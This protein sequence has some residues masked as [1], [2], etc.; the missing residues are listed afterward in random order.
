MYNNGEQN[1]DLGQGYQGNPGNPVNQSNPGN[2]VNQSNTGNPGNPGNPGNQGYQQGYQSNQSNQ[3]NQ[4]N[5]SAQGYQN[6]QGYKEEQPTESYRLAPKYGAYKIGENS[7]ETAY[8]PQPP[9]NGNS[10]N[11]AS[12]ANNANNVNNGRDNRNGRN[13][14]QNQNS[15]MKNNYLG[16]ENP[17]ADFDDDMNVQNQNAQNQN[18]QNQNA[19]PVNAQPVNAQPQ[20]GQ[21]QNVQNQNA[22]PVN[23]QPVNAQ[24]QDTQSA[25]EVVLEPSAEPRTAKNPKF[26]TSRSNSGNS[27]S[28]APR[29]PRDPRVPR[30]PRNPRDSRDHRDSRNNRNRGASNGS[31]STDYASH[32]IVAVISAFV[33]AIV[34]I[35]V[36]M[37]AINNGF[38]QIPQVGSLSGIGASNAITG[39]KGSAIVKGGA[40]PNW[41]NVAKNVCN[42]VVSI[43][44]RTSKMEGKGSGAIVD[45]QGHVVTNNHVVAGAEQIQVTLANG[46]IYKAEVVGTDK[47]TDLAVLKIVNPPRNLKPV[48]FANS[49]NLA[50]GEP[51]MAIGNPLGYANTATAGI[52]SSL[53]RPVSVMDDNSRSEIITDSVQ[54]DAAINPGNSGGPTFNAAG[55]VIGINSSIAAAS[56]KANVSGSIGIGFAIPSN[57]A[58]RVV[59]E[60]IS[61][62]SVKHVALGIMIKNSLVT[63]GNVSRGGAEIVS[64]TPG[65][66]AAKAGLRRGDNIVAFNNEPVSSNYSLLGYVRATAFNQQATIT[67]VRGARTI[68]LNVL[69]NQEEASVIGETRKDPHSRRQRGRNKGDNNSKNPKDNKRDKDDDDDDLQPRG[70]NDD[71][72]GIFDPFGFW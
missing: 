4:S 41:V 64:V 7:S 20:N 9:Y 45:A 71:D 6:A 38:I 65:T 22:Q 32:M 52:V 39:G 14:Q 68:K 8:P 30:D 5:Q 24:P 42:S 2:P 72:G 51:V 69:F 25:H 17:Y 46:E 53:H 36:T 59:N 35:V 57:L 13:G 18:A 54:I 16:F 23:A 27:N 56:S 21:P 28:D 70:D 48:Q 62:G 55:Q 12:N 61:N 66:P 40:A 49:D 29:D 1:P 31:G 34:C 47:T 33:A 19:Q 11:N 26:G 3:T 37:F 63:S 67:V 15:R 44:M 60:I 10:Y 50:V 43:Q 58:K